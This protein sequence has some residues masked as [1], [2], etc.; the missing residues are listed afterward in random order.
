MALSAIPDGRHITVQQQ[1]RKCGK[2]PCNTCSQN[3]GHGPYRYAYWRVGTVH[4]TYIG[5]EL[6]SSIIDRI[7]QQKVSAT[8][9]CSFVQQQQEA[10][11][12]LC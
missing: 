7:A 9:A 6:P 11:A 5:K 2:T 3:G 12:V 8:P 10:V 4:S 1:L